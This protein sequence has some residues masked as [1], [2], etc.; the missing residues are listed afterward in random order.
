HDSLPSKSNRGQSFDGY[1][2]DQ[3]NSAH[4]RPQRSKKE[5]GAIRA[6]GI[7]GEV[8]DILEYSSFSA[9]G[10]GLIIL[11]FASPSPV[12]QEDK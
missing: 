1:D 7:D 10:W 3:R 5:T 9:H 12:T 6:E 8:K 2:P 4:D 11:A